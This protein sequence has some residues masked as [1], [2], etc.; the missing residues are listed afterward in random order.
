M[1]ELDFQDSGGFGKWAGNSGRLR[2][3]SELCFMTSEIEGST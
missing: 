3:P 2:P 1:G